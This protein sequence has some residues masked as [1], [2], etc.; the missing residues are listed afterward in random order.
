LPS[1]TITLTREE[2]YRRIWSTPTEKPAAE[3]GISDVALGKTCRKFNIPKPQRG[4]WRRR[5]AGY[6]VTL[7]PLPPCRVV[8][9]TTIV[10]RG[11]LSAE[12]GGC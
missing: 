3:F 9:T 5:E 8:E 1:D 12:V 11:T 4:Y 2:L 7:R 6:K 10:I